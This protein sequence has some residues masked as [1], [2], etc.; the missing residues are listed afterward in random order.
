MAI[1]LSIDRSIDREIYDNE[2]SPWLPERIYDCH[3]HISLA[4]NCGHL[5]PERRKQFW[6]MEVGV[7]QTWEELRENHRRLFPGRDVDTLAFGGV[8]RE[9]D[10]RRENDYVLSG[11][12]NPL[13][14]ADGLLVTRPE[15][16]AS[17]IEDGMAKGF[18][19]IKPYPDLAPQETLEISVFDFVPHAHLAMLNDLKGVLMLHL[20]RAGR[21]GDPENVRELLEIAERYPSIRLIVA[22]IGRAYCLPAAEESLPQFADVP[23]VFFDTSANLN[24]DVFQLAME[25]I[26]PDRMLF[27]TDLPVMMMRG[28]RDHVGEDYVNYTNGAYSWNTNRKSPEEEAC[29]SYYVYEQLRALIK[30]AKCV[31]LDKPAFHKILYHNTAKL[32]GKPIGSLAV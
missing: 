1:N 11:L 20:P 5:S 27:G 26:R 6:T 4:E 18:I 2:L 16:D 29:Y 12:R 21:L 32:L 23:G 25:T 24:A 13:N 30:A 3:A 19:G 28:C 8:Y 9:Q 14:R 31:G 15:W 22:H 7:F 17:M 10:S